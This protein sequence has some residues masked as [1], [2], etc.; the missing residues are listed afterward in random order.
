MEQDLHYEAG[1]RNCLYKNNRDFVV[2][3]S[4]FPKII[5]SGCIRNHQ[6]IMHNDWLLN[7][8][9]SILETL[10]RTIPLLGNILGFSKLFSIFAAPIKKDSKVDIAVHTFAGILEML[11][12]GLIILALKI[13][14]TIIFLL[15]RFSQKQPEF[16]QCPIRYYGDII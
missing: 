11:G 14:F 4:R 2:H 13:I 16:A 9:K 7:N 6:G 5:Q 3:A 12:L 15:W 10:A 8:K 1:S